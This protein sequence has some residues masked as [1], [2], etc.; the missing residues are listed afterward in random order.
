M[1][2]TRSVQASLISLAQLRSLAPTD[3]EGRG[4]GRLL[5]VVVRWNGTEPYPLVTGIVL[6]L[7]DRQIFQPVVNIL[8]LDARTLMVRTVQ[9]DAA[10]F[11]RREGE[12]RLVQD[13]LGRQSVDV[14]GVNVFRAEDL[15]VASVAGRL[16]LVAVTGESRPWW[17]RLLPAAS[18]ERRRLVDWSAVHPFGDPGSELR[19]Q[20]P[21]EGLRRLHAGE[22]ADLL[23]KLDQRGR[24]ELTTALDPAAVADALEE[25]EPDQIEDILRDAPPE[26]AAALISAMEPDEAVDVLRDMERAEA[27]A[28]LAHVAPEVARQLTVLLGYPETM[29]GGFMTTALAKVRLSATVMDARQD[30]AAQSAHS[31]DID[32]VAVVDDGGRLIADLP[33]F[34]L[35]VADD[36]TPLSELIPDSR[37][38]TLHPEA[39]L[40]EVVDRLTEA[41]SSSVVVVDAEGKPIGRV[42]ADDVIDALKDGGLRTK[43]P[44]LF[45]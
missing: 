19:L 41:R 18:A 34:D 9:P 15:F 44:W 8:R 2:A 1:L 36:H 25:M 16:R 24:D 30:L 22:L 6:Q 35:L 10:G 20:V 26:R 5:D 23:E 37:P 14:D 45:H 33:L 29:A 42:L 12:L 11:S 4:V 32:S 28:I 40:D 17:A 27:D 21:N 31:A 43:L 3:E 38:V 7:G 13:V 39:F